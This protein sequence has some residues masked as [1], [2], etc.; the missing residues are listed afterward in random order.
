M[1]TQS[2]SVL[3]SKTKGRN[4][5]KKREILLF[6]DEIGKGMCLTNIF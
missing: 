4:I 2:T 5:M 1:N 6:H 3:R